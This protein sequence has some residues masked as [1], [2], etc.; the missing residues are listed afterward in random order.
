MVLWQFKSCAGKRS[1]N[2]VA[3]NALLVVADHGQCIML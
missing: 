2:L 1:T 3:L